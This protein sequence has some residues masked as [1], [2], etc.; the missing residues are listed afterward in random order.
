VIEQDCVPCLDLHRRQFD[1][2]LSAEVRLDP[3]PDDVAVRSPRRQRQLRS[4]ALD[5]LL[6]ER[7]ERLARRCN[8]GAVLHARQGVVERGLGVLLR[9]ESGDLFLRPPTVGVETE[10]DPVAPRPPGAAGLAHS[11]PD[12]DHRNR[13]STSLVDVS[14][15]RDRHVRL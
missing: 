8:V 12:D 6:E 4:G 15:T 11:P 3:T 10:I 7:G 1:E 13:L 9:S 2:A 5:P 14:W